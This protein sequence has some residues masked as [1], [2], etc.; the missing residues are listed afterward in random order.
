MYL[1]WLIP[2]Q[3]FWVNMSWE[4][5]ET[6]IVWGTVMEYIFSYPIAKAIAKYAPKISLYLEEK[7][8]NHE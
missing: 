2:F 5:F 3:L 6:W 4:Q 7:T 1:A 8:T